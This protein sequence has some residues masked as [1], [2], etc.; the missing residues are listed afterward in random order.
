MYT[1]IELF[2]S[3]LSSFSGTNANAFTDKQV[4]VWDALRA[5]RRNVDIPEAKREVPLN[6]VMVG[7]EFLYAEPDD[8]DIP[9][10][11]YPVQGRTVGERLND[12]NRVSNDVMDNGFK[13]Y[14]TSVEYTRD[15][16]MGV[17]LLRINSGVSQVSDLVLQ[18]FVSLT[19]DGTVTVTGDGSNEGIS[20][21]WFLTDNGSLTFD[22][23][24]STGVS[25]VTV[26][27]TGDDIKDI[28]DISADG[29][30]TS[31]I[32]VPSVLVGK[33]TNIKLRLGNDSSNY[34]E[35][36]V[37]SNSYGGV[38]TEGFNDIII[39]RRSMT[40]TGTV[41]DSAISYMQLRITHTMGAGAVAQGVRVDN[42]KAS[43]G[44]GM[45]Y[46]YYSKYLFMD[47]T[48]GAFMD[49]PA[50]AS[51]SEKLI[52]NKDTFDLAVLELRKVLDM[53]RAG[54][55]QS[56]IWRNAQRDLFGLQGIQKEEGAYS[57]YRRRFPSD[58]QP[59]ITSYVS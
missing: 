41:D 54:N 24:Q 2:N 58:R 19:E 7:G 51:L 22:I 53:K 32:F 56:D 1:T 46:K 59:Q 39:P 55:N 57:K 45:I 14:G 21:V 18:N 10:G 25:N 26:V 28:S 4:L 47:A 50:S 3:A 11:I 27:M 49:K 5:V 33:I 43:Y 42:I 15:Y 31:S 12:F 13:T 8:V 35:G 9:L 40:T 34:I 29:A 23:T 37:T 38:F 17:P 20:D 52:L 44:V 48:T 36:T 30:F 6:P 16:R